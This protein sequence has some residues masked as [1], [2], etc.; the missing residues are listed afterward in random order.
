LELK[1]PEIKELSLAGARIR[2]VEILPAEDF[3]KLRELNLNN[4]LITHIKGISQ[5]SALQNLKLNNNKIE[6]FEG[7]C[8]HEVFRAITPHINT[9]DG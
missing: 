2:E 9:L 5:L 7:I 8:E 1:R 6:K 4:N 3:P